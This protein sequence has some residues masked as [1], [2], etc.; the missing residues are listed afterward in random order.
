MRRH[1]AARGAEPPFWLARLRW[2]LRGRSAWP[3]L[4][5][6]LVVGGV[7]LDALPPTGDPGVGVREVLELTGVL[8]LLA[9]VGAAT[10]SRLLR[11]RDPSLPRLVARDRA[12]TLALLVGVLGLAVG[13]ILHRPAV[14]AKQERLDAMVAEARSL[15]ERR[16]PE[17]ARRRLDEPDVRAL[18]VDVLRICFP[19]GRADRAWC[20]VVR[21]DAGTPRAR[22]DSDPR[23][24]AVL[25]REAEE[26]S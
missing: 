23:S 3:A 9:T 22:T 20:A 13:G 10:G 17:Y 18:S 6:A 25:E 11:R 4:V 26:A 5:A 16:A 24:N 2:R 12:A 21:R 14:V 8:L 19:V 15:A 1:R 7:L